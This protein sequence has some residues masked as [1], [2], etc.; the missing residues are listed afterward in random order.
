MMTRTLKVL[1]YSA[2]PAKVFFR[3]TTAPEGDVD[4]GYVDDVEYVD[5]ADT[6]VE[7]PTSPLL[8]PGGRPAG[9]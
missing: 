8:A 2:P 9:V 5:L 4:V 6:D 7:A 3:V 1:A